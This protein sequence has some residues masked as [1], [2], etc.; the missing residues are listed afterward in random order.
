MSPTL[1]LRNATVLTMD[2]QRPLADAVLVEDGCISW[3]GKENDVSTVCVDRLIDCGGATLLPGLNDAHIHLLAYAASLQRM[4][5]SRNSIASIE[6]LPRLLQARARTT[7]AGQWIRGSGYDLFY[8]AEQ[9]HPTRHD[10]DHVT[11]HH[12]VRLDHHSGHACVLNS[13]GLEA[14]GIT[15]DT[16]DPVDGV[17]KRNEAGE[18]TGVLLE[19]N[20]YISSRMNEVR[21]GKAIY[22]SVAEAGQRLLRWGLTSLQEA[23]PGNDPERWDIFDRLIQ[24]GEFHQRLMVMPG[25]HYLQQFTERGLTYG[26]G[27][28]H[29]RIGPAK[30]MATHTTGVLQPPEEQIRKLVLEVHQMGSPIAIHAVE[31]ETILAVARALIQAADKHH[32]GLYYRDRIEHCAEATPKVLD[33]LEGSGIALVTQPGFLYEN[34]E[35]YRA[36]VPCEIQPWIYPLRA[37]QQA[38]IPLAAGS[39]SPV[40]SPNPWEGIYAAITRRCFSGEALHPEQGLTLG[41]A[42]LLWTR[43]AAYASAEE[44][45]KG[46]L[47]PGMLA[48]FI[49]MDRDITRVE[50]EELLTCR[51]AMTVV[52]GEVVWER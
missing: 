4:D 3:V 7:P 8:L 21:D 10:L 27:D 13:R 33:L 24:A 34:G 19:M 50:P 28:Q 37:L 18:P 14:V 2:A 16:S 5:C 25:V 30:L 36:E 47:C 22:R 43:G 31:Q 29:L 52:N 41:G 45:I 35:R 51:V 38:G 40:A 6:D 46:I 49:L 17:I 42:L 32:D 15:A 44:K 23:S 39:D 20:D 1:L 11:P 48:D 9:R 26:V 12:P